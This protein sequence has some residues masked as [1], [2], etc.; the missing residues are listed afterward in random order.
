MA[1]NKL[2]TSDW[3]FDDGLDFSFEADIDGALNQSETSKKKERSV[4]SSVV[5]GAIDGAKD[6]LKSPSFYRQALRQALPSTYG[7][8]ADGAEIIAE[9]SYKILDDSVK[10]LKP[11]LGQIVK[12]LDKLVPENQKALKALTEK[13]KRLTGVE[14]SRDYAGTDSQEDQLVTSSLAA[15]FEQNKQYTQIAERKQVVRDRVESKMHDQSVGLLTSID[16]STKTSAL[17]TTNVTQ[18]YQKKS[19]EL[20]L[21]TYSMQR[22][23][24]TKSIN[25]LEATKNQLEAVI[26]NTALP[27]Y[28]KI[29]NSER[30]MELSKKRLMDS[31]YDR[32]NP[33]ARGM[34]KIGERIGGYVSGISYGLDNFDFALDGVTGAREQLE[35]MNEMLV[36]M[37][38]KPLTKEQM[39]AAAATSAGLSKVRDWVT[40]KIRARTE[41]MNPLKEKLARGA[42][43][44]L[45]PGAEIRKFRESE[46]WQS[47]IGNYTDARGGI[48]RFFDSFMDAFGDDNPE[49]KLRSGGKIEDLNN[50]T[51]GFDQKAHIS[52]VDIIPGHL[53]AIRRE[54]T[55]LRTGDTSTPLTV[56]DFQRRSFTDQKTM[57][58]VVRDTVTKKSVSGMFNW[59]LQSAAK[60]MGGGAELNQNEEGELKVFLA[61]LSRVGDLNLEPDEIRETAAYQDLPDHIRPIVDLYLD[62]VENSEEKEQKILELTRTVRRTR[63]LMPSASPDM[64]DFVDSGHIE[65]LRKMGLIREDENGNITVDEAKFEELQDNAIKATTYRS[66]INV[67]EA[68]KKMAPDELLKSVNEKLR[69]A[70]FKSSGT[71]W[72]GAQ[73]YK[74]VKNTNLYSWSYKAGEGEPGVKTGP[75][76]Q[77]VRRNLGEDVAPDG[78]AIDIQSMNGALMAAVQHLGGKV[79][80]ITGDAKKPQAKVSVL[81]QIEINTAELVRMNREALEAVKASGGQG[82]GSGLGNNG[83][84]GSLAGSLVGNIVDLATK[85]SGDIFHAAGKTYEFGKEEFAKPLAGFLSKAYNNSKDPVAKGI[86]ALFTKGTDF[87]GSVLDFGKKALTE[88]L[89]AGF[90]SIR[91]FATSTWK[92]IKDFFNETKDLYLPEGTEPVI[93]AVKL[94]MGFYRD[95]ATGKVIETMDELLACKNDIVDSAGNIVLSLE[96]KANGLYDKHGNKV[97]TFAMNMLHGALGAGIWLKDKVKSGLSSLIEAGSGGLDGIKNMF[98]NKF[99]GFGDVGFGGKYIKSSYE[100][101]V[102]IREIMLGRGKSVIDRMSADIGPKQPGKGGTPS[103][104]TP[105]RVPSS[106]NSIQG[107]IETG[108]RVAGGAKTFWEKTGIGGKLGKRF[109]F[110]LGGKEKKPEEFVGPLPEMVGPMQP[111]PQEP[112]GPPKPTLLQSGMGKLSSFFGRFGKSDPPSED[113]QT[114]QPSNPEQ[115][116]IN[117][118]GTVIQQGDKRD[119]RSHASDSPDFVGPRMPGPVKTEA[120]EIH[121]P[122]KPTQ[123]QTSGDASESGKKGW[124]RSAFDS[125]R[126]ESQIILQ[127]G[128]EA[129]QEAKKTY[130]EN[131]K[132]KAEKPEAGQTTKSDKKEQSLLQKIESPLKGKSGE[133]TGERKGSVKER[134]EKIEKMHQANQN[135]AAKLD[136]NV[137]NSQAPDMMGGVKNGILAAKLGM[138]V[139]KIGGGIVSRM[140]DKTKG[141]RY[142]KAKGKGLLGK[143]GFGKKPEEVQEDADK[144]GKDTAVNPDDTVTQ[145]GEASDKQSHASDSPDFVGPKLPGKEAK[146]DPESKENTETTYDADG[147][148]IKKPG[149]MDRIFG[150]SKKFNDSDG[151]G[152][153][154][155]GVKDREE[156]LKKL[157]ESRKKKDAPS[158]GKD[159]EKKGDFGIGSL[160]SGLASAVGMLGKGFGGIFSLITGGFKGVFKLFGGLGKVMGGLWKGAKFAGKGLGTAARVAGTVGRFALTRALPAIAMGGLNMAGAA[161]GG[162]ASVLGSPVV[163]GAAAI[164]VTAYGAYKAYKYFTRNNINDFDRIRLRQYGFCYDEL[165]EKHN[166]KFLALENYLYDGRLKFDSGGSASIN[167]RDVKSEEILDIFDIDPEDKE[168]VNRFTDWIGNRFKPFFLHHA[169]T[170]FRIKPKLKLEDI[171]EKLDL[172]EKIQ[173]LETAY[174]A[175]GPYGVETSPIKSIETANTDSKSVAEM[176]DNLTKKLVEEAKKTATKEKDPFRLTPTT[177]ESTEK[178]KMADEVIKQQESKKAEPPPGDMAKKAAE[179]LGATGEDGKVPDAPPTNAPETTSKL[180]QAV[181]TA[182]GGV[183][184]G[185]NGREFVKLGR[186]MTENHLQG[187]HPGVLKLFL[188]MAEEYNKLTGKTVQMNEGL[189]T[190][191]EQAALRRKYGN[192]AAKPGTSLH[193]SGLAIDIPRVTAAEL[194]K[195]GLM[196]KYGFT[197]PVGGEPWHLEPAGIQKNVQLARDNRKEADLLVETSPFRGGGGYAMVADA[198]EGGRN[199]ALAVSLLNREPDMS[200]MSEQPVNE[201]D[202]LQRDVAETKKEIDNVVAN[203]DGTKSSVQETASKASQLPS[204]EEVKAVRENNSNNAAINT[205][206]NSGGGG[207]GGGGAGGMEEPKVGETSSSSTPI[208]GRGDSSIKDIITNAAKKV[209]LDPKTLLAF[210][211]VES[212]MNPNAKAKTSSAAGLFQFINST[213]KEVLGKFGKKHGLPAN[214]SPFDPEASSLMAAEYLKQ[215]AKGLSSVKSN[216]NPTDLYLTHFLGLGGARKF[217]RISPEG[218]PAEQMQAAAQANRNI[219][220]D[221]S[222]QAKTSRMVYSSLSEK[223]QKKAALY[224]VDISP[225][226]L[227]GAKAA[228]DDFVS[229]AEAAPTAPKFGTTGPSSSVPETATPA[230]GT[231]GKPTA[232]PST[233]AANDSSV[234]SVGEEKTPVISGETKEPIRTETGGVF[235]DPNGGSRQ[236]YE[237]RSRSNDNLAPTLS[238]VD[239]TLKSSLEV[240]R[241]SLDVLKTI[242]NS[243]NPEAFAKVLGN[244][245]GKSGEEKTN[246]LKEADRRNLGTYKRDQN[247]TLDLS[248]RAA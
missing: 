134:E 6:T 68:I 218:K 136:P 240:Q 23:Y 147:K 164:A 15:I 211:A 224:G 55:I 101:L 97:K 107:A 209:G 75:M 132:A 199:Q 212:D 217:L 43:M 72:K 53:A 182:P 144:T 60:M 73:A 121:G 170:L 216:A 232:A 104:P 4:V 130:G 89:P 22:E 58:K 245:A 31:L 247:P 32:G 26:K 166:H 105:A 161:L 39:A 116:Q 11:R 231:A 223:I 142:I 42:R 27:E 110:L 228:N 177:K 74:G 214:A 76:A 95:A 178:V 135:E 126:K 195:L 153:R 13:V 207:G 98:K 150:K 159:K 172:K 242:M 221:K 86:K 71:N 54:I 186:G 12:K 118:D 47:K 124:F 9:G 151:D 62:S 181:K 127:G 229:N 18:A 70:Q 28:V 117:P 129:Y 225:S 192:R 114:A 204:P 235:L 143:I 173:Y 141:G 243:L 20:Q 7:E 94:R 234:M 238:S 65:S 183:L 193:E 185:S 176:V 59:E 48:F 99:Q 57:D 125:L 2:E 219:F 37:G 111:T 52:L 119:N 84:Y 190:F 25:Y 194:E 41:K 197:R 123:D 180:S 92:T 80:E 24:Y 100:V 17:Y 93:R 106:I 154:D 184:D 128:K 81:G 63:E 175:S 131:A 30:F 149:L 79:D 187:L 112:M 202:A 38:E 140:M 108:K 174:M 152:D 88:H 34:K 16:Q 196:R 77:D 148:K 210:A 236:A 171:E 64:K 50:P 51:M 91:D 36:S 226:T 29:T 155:A 201:S 113:Q 239:N 167:E 67:K 169:T 165:S 83:S 198:K 40:D 133:E 145:N 158:A 56:Y 33:L 122:P 230:Y 157:E 139:G 69:G 146:K 87:A 168:M 189:R 21:R 109:G 90:R 120:P 215:N 213:W 244:A 78:K 160:I 3:N 208:T 5:D 248:R 162:I 227:G 10:E 188:G 82:G 163:L 8:I 49:R 103:S 241:E 102:D 205:A 137:M 233:P 179:A 44:V 19:L 66:D 222:G 115:P 156:K 237:A 191:E 61:R 206:V 46:K 246:P 35:Q 200:Q 203:S 138:S 220:F 85:V 96:E 45:N 14:E 1:K